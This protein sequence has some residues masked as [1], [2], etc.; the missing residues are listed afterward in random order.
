MAGSQPVCKNVPIKYWSDF[1]PTL[2]LVPTPNQ[3]WAYS[4]GLEIDLFSPLC[5][6]PDVQPCPSVACHL[7]P[8]R[9]GCSSVIG[10]PPTR[11]PP[12]TVSLGLLYPAP[13]LWIII[14]EASLMFLLSPQVKP[15]N[16]IN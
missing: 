11:L 16:S 10:H 13:A 6:L 14:L 15:D 8:Q 9:C 2:L 7:Y 12:Q 4:A 3:T 5:T 1:G